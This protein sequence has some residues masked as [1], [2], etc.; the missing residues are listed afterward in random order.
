M[1]L[2]EEYDF[3]LE[4]GTNHIQHTVYITRYIRHDMNKKLTKVLIKIRPYRNF[5][6]CVI[7]H[8]LKGY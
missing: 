4:F 8:L 7:Q 3:D 1:K 5:V 2:K 6:S